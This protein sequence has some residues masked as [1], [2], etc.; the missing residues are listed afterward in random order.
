MSDSTDKKD[1]AI[2]TEEPAPKD[3]LPGIEAGHYVRLADRALV[4][5]PKMTPVKLFKLGW[6]NKFQVMGVGR[7][8][9][10]GG[11]VIK[12]D[13]CCDWMEDRDGKKHLC[14]GHPAES[15]ELYPTKKKK[16][17]GDRYFSVDVAGQDLISVEY[18][19]GDEDDEALM[20][21]FAGQKPFTIAGGAARALARILQEKGFF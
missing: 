19:N 7:D 15:F 2:S 18:I 5:M 6:P 14:A 16:D 10:T 21:R 1:E 8:P 12:I 20:V 13:P 11:Q 4:D 17:D 9:K 3:A